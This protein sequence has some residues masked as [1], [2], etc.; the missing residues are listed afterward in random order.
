M[1]KLLS[2]LFLTTI[3]CCCSTIS[4]PF[5]PPAGAISAIK[6]PLDID[7]DNIKV[8]A[9]SGSTSGINILGLV[10]IGDFSYETAAKNGGISVIKASSYEY[11]N[12]F[13]LFQKTTVNVYGD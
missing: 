1:K 5:V 12:V 4:A 10:S 13:W 9:K 11:L 8:P 3:T 6:A 7:L 2:V